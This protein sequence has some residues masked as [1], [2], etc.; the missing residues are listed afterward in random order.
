MKAEEKINTFVI[1]NKSSKYKLSL[2][3]G[4]CEIKFHLEE[5]ESL[6]KIT[7][8]ENFTLESLKQKSKFFLL[9]ETIEELMPDMLDF[10]KNKKY[11]LSFETNCAMISLFLPMRLVEEIILPIPQTESDPNSVIQELTITINKLNK[12]IKSMRLEMNEM[13]KL[14][15]EINSMK[16]EMNEMKELNKEINSMKL[17]MNEMKELKKEIKS[18]KV[19]MNEMLNKQINPMKL[20]MNEMI[21][22]QINPMKVEMN[23]MINKQINPM[24]VEMNEMKELNKEI[25]SMKVEMNEMKELNKEINSMKLEMNK[26]KELNEEINSMKLEMKELNNKQINSMKLEM[27]EMKEFIDQ[28]KEVDYIVG[29]INRNKALQSDKIIIDEKEKKLICDWISVDRKVNMTLLYKATRD[30]DSSSTFHNKCNGKSPTLTLVKT[31]NGYRCGGFTSLPW[32]SFRDY[33]ED[34]DA[35]VFSMDTRSKYKSTNSNSIYCHSDY[36]PTFGDGYDL[37]LENKFL[38][39]ANSNRCNCPSTYKTVKQSELTGGEYNFTVKECEVYQ[40]SYDN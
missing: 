12:Q 34:N 11:S 29:S 20:E 24:K 18:M 23:E 16:V 26:M 17:E 36:G 13:N 19:E 7:F 31:S 4:K 15:K 32:D 1:E 30:G 37:C 14:N 25:K 10:F 5:L 3:G 22:K 8:E 33:K 28:L 2:E 6:P 38:T 21:N 35:F 9:F 39:A 40:I 27:N